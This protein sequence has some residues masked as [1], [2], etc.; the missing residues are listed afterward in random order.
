[1]LGSATAAASACGASAVCVAVELPPNKDGLPLCTC[2]LFHN[3][4]SE[5]EKIIHRTVRRISI[6]PVF[7]LKRSK[8]PTVYRRPAE[9]QMRVS[10][11]TRAALNLKYTPRSEEHTSE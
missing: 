9:R 4:K 6:A 8:S 7:E 10:V 3:S 11:Y 1:M 2:Q 5:S